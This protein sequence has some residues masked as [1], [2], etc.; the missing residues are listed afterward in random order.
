MTLTAS[1]RRWSATHR[2]MLSLLG[3]LMIA[4]ALGIVNAPVARAQPSY[5]CPVEGAKTI[6]IND[7]AAAATININEN[8]SDGQA[9]YSGVLRDISCDDRRPYLIVGYMV[10]GPTVWLPREVDFD[11]PDGCNTEAT[12][13][14]DI[15]DPEPFVEA[16]VMA[17]IWWKPTGSS[18]GDCQVL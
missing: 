8:C 15:D 5:T 18:E 16:C 4:A 12:F 7:G 11:A 14:F 9:H 10:S 1:L 17:S 6:E 13:A 3:A 2:R